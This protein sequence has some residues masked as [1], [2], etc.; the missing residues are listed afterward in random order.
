MS[1]RTIAKTIHCGS[2]TCEDE[3]GHPCE[4]IVPRFGDEGEPYWYCGV[5]GM[6]V[7]AR[8]R[9]SPGSSVAMTWKRLEECKDAERRA[10]K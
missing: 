6:K 9:V 3:S 10:A 2:L 8:T 5:H 7:E 1:E 4:C